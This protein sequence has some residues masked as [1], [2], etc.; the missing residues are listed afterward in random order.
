MTNDFLALENGVIEMDSLI[1]SLRRKRHGKWGI[2]APEVFDPLFKHSDPDTMWEFDNSGKFHGPTFC[3]TVEVIWSFLASARSIW[4]SP[5]KGGF[6]LISDERVSCPPS[7]PRGL[8]NGYL[9]LVKG[10]VIKRG[11]VFGEGKT[12][13]T[14]QGGEIAYVSRREFKEFQKHLEDWFLEVV[15][16]LD[17]SAYGRSRYE[18]TYLEYRSNAMIAHSK[19]R[20]TKDL[21]A[22]WMEYV[23]HFTEPNKPNKDM[24][25]AKY[26]ALGIGVRRGDELH[27]K[28]SPPYWKRVGSKKIY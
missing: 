1:E 8:D 10:S 26:V 18:P 9:S 6:S 13:D 15:C 24:R 2:A 19:F 25:R 21:E 5:S 4:V 12:V 28:L 23:G 22:E 3:A 11:L 14:C 17:E 16:V 20:T 7:K 27:K